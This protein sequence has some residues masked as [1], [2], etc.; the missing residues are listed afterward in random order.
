MFVSSQ[1]DPPNFR[2]STGAVEGTGFYAGFYPGF[3]SS[4]CIGSAVSPGTPWEPCE[5]IF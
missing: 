4:T 3:R 2:P 5:L 1:D